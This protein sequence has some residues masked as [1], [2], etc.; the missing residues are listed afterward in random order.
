VIRVAVHGGGHRDRAERLTG[1]VLVVHQCRKVYRLAYVRNRMSAHCVECLSVILTLLGPVTS[2]P[3]ERVKGGVRGMC[4]C[5][6]RSCA[7][8]AADKLRIS[9]RLRFVCL[10]AMA[11]C[12]SK[13]WNSGIY[14]NTVCLAPDSADTSESGA[15]GGAGEIVVERFVEGHGERRGMCRR[16]NSGSILGPVR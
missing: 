9:W 14:G 15:V 1:L 4:H 5:F 7:Q 10:A 2:I 13:L 3:C 8:T 12:R 6:G 16:W 11:F